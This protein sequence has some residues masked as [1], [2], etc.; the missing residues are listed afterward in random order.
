VRYFIGFLWVIAPGDIHNLTVLDNQLRIELIKAVV[1]GV[2][3][4]LGNSLD[5]R[6]DS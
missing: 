4:G 6:D 1:F 2:H 5:A 3:D